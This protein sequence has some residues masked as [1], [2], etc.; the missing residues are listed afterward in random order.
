MPQVGREEAVARIEQCTA[1]G[2]GLDL[3]S[4]VAGV[5]PHCRLLP[6]LQLTESDAANNMG[7]L[8]FYFGERESSQP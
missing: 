3:L 2:S 6:Y 7:D 4:S 8:T 5:A 1:A